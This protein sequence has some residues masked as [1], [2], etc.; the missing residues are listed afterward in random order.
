MCRSVDVVLIHWD[1]L[2]ICILWLNKRL[3][4]RVGKNDKVECQ[5]SWT[6][7]R[8]SIQYLSKNVDISTK[9]QKSKFTSLTV[10]LFEPIELRVPG[11]SRHLNTPITAWRTQRRS[12]PSLW[13]A[14]FAAT[15]LINKSTLYR[16]NS[17]MHRLHLFSPI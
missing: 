17:I 14:T 11:K 15:A 6:L 9:K 10:R 3:G 12:A 1:F 16:M 5:M 4:R 2:T 7:L 13:K 8:L